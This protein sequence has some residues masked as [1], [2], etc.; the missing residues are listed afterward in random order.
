MIFIVKLL[1]KKVLDLKDNMY[2][3]GIYYNT[4]ELTER[5]QNGLGI[6]SELGTFKYK[7]ENNLV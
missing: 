7:M 5:V 2:F 1:R 4:I 3:D 6:N